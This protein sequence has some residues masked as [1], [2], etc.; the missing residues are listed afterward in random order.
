MEPFSA[1]L[2]SNDASAVGITGKVLDDY[3]VKVDVAKTVPDMANLMEYRRY[4]LAVYDQDVPGATELAS[5]HWARNRPRLVMALVRKGK[6]KEL[7]GKSIHL[8]VP[9]PFT[10]NLFIKSIRAAYSLIVKDRRAAFRCPIQADALSAKLVGAGGGWPLDNVKLIN[11][12]QSGLCVQAQEILPKGA[13]RN[14]IRVA[15][16]QEAGA[17]PGNGYLE[18]RVQQGRHQVW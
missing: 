10:S 9:K 15:G 4:D 3:D 11:I 8:I 12:S 6:M 18:R 2:I 14:S 16:K 1:L 17:R 13:D 5:S 7:H